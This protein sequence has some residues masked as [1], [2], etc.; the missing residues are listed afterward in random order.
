MYFRQLV[1]QSKSSD[2]FRAFLYYSTDFLQPEKECEEI[3]GYGDSVLA[4]ATD[5]WN[6]FN[7][8]S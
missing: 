7:E 1:V 2:D 5:A 3:R 8:I 6:R 4:A